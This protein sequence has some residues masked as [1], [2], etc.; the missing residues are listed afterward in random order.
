MASRRGL[1][2][3]I[4]PALA[5][6]TLAAWYLVAG[7][8]FVAN[9]YTRGTR[10]VLRNILAGEGPFT[11]SDYLAASDALVWGAVVLGWLLAAVLFAD[12]FADPMMAQ[13][14]RATLTAS[15]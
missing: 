4:V 1:I 9:A 12:H 3:A 13:M 10:A 8:Q 2:V 5:S 6:S 7:N 15:D 14:Y 11:L